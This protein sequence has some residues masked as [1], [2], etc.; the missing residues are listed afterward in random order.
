MKAS[1]QAKRSLQTFQILRRTPRS[2]PGLP[3]PSWGRRGFSCQSLPPGRQGN[4][5]LHLGNFSRLRTRG[6][7]GATGSKP[8]IQVQRSHD[9]FLGVI[10]QHFE[11]QMLNM[12]MGQLGGAKCIDYE[13]LFE[14]TPFP[15]Q[16]HGGVLK[17]GDPFVVLKGNQADT[18]YLEFLILRDTHIDCR[19]AHVK[20]LLKGTSAPTFCLSD[21]EVALKSNVQLGV[22]RFWGPP[23][24]WW[25]PFGCPIKNHQERGIFNKKTPPITGRLFLCD[26]GCGLL[27]PVR[28]VSLQLL[29]PSQGRGGSRLSR[30]TPS[31]PWLLLEEGPMV[32]N[33]GQNNG[34]KLWSARI[35]QKIGSFRCGWGI[36]P[37]SC[38]TETISWRLGMSF[39]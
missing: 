31:A 27:L 29:R 25:P 7:P 35:Q 17:I 37:A 8:V 34:S 13:L 24:W 20:A 9:L 38:S 30:R 2:E 6:V 1:T 11:P 3:D 26:Q 18:T 28:V 22:T 10:R 32:A 15:V 16:P 12:P 39:L 5:W 14:H 19:T 23:Q 36:C 4:S 33:S 21:H